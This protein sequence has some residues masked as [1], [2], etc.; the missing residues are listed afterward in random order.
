MHLRWNAFA[1]IVNG[2]L[3]KSSQSR[4]LTVALDTTP[5]LNIDIKVIYTSFYVFEKINYIARQWICVPL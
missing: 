1:T 4:M 5:H 3:L 2:L